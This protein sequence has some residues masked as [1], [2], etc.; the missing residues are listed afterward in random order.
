MLAEW[1]NGTNPVINLSLSETGLLRFQNAAEQAGVAKPADHYTIVWSRFDNAV[2]RPHAGRRRAD[3][4]H[5]LGAGAS[6][7]A[8]SAPFVAATIKAFHPDQPALAAAGRSSTS[9]GVPTARG[10]SSGL[11]RNP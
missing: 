4:D 1:L 5:D 6:R 9:G 3:G 8:V 11:E 10:R 7:A 2:E